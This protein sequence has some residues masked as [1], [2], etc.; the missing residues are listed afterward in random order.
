MSTHQEHGLLQHAE[1]YHSADPELNTKQVAP[2]E[3]AEDE[4]HEAHDD[5]HRAHAAI[6]NQQ[7]VVD[8]G[9][10]PVRTWQRAREL[11]FQVVDDAEII[12]I[13]T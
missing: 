12:S 11:E 2:V 10:V 1:K 6:K 5:V 13:I 3:G 4:P 7:W 9:K 8:H